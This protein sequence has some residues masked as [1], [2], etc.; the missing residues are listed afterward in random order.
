MKVTTKTQLFSH[1]DSEMKELGRETGTKNSQRRSSKSKEKTQ[2]K[3]DKLQK[4]NSRHGNSEL[5]NHT[6]RL[7]E[8]TVT[9]YINKRHNSAETTHTQR[10]KLVEEQRNSKQKRNP[11]NV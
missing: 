11:V 4:R 10:Q 5:G 8:T 9:L 3:L 6:T 7:A 2:Q 1:G